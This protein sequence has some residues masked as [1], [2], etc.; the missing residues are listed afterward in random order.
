MNVLDSSGW[1]EFFADGP[2]AD[3]FAEP[4]TEAAMLLVPVIT[5]YEVFKKVLL[6]R[7]ESAAL[8][9]VALMRHGAIVGLES[10]TA[11]AA[12]KL[13]VDAH[14]PMADALILA[15]ARQYGATLWTQDRDFEGIEGVRYIEKRAH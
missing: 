1:L 5:V 3:A 14:L 8:E 10:A 2:N 4:L 13:S 6:Q 7:D 9:A 12:A 11:L 15:T